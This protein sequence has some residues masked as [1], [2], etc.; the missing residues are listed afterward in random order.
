MGSNSAPQPGLPDNDLNSTPY[1]NNSD[2]NSI[3]HAFGTG[4]V[5]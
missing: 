5:T 3:I 1:I 4:S 2:N